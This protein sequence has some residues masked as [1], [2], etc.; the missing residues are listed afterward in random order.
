MNPL[1]KITLITPSFN[2]GLFIEKTIKSVLEQGYPDL[3]HI[4]IDGGSTDQTLDI[5]RAYGQQLT[6]LSEPDRGQTHAINKG[7]RLATGEV[8]GYVNSDDMLLPGSLLKV[9]HFFRDHPQASW[10]TGRCRMIDQN[11]EE[12]RKLITFYKNLWL[13]MR[14]SQMLAVMDYI[15]QPATFWRRQVI[16]DVGYFDERHNYAMDYDYWLRLGKQY[17]LWYLDEYLAC[18]RLHPA[19]KGGSS[20]EAQFE[21]DMQVAR[22]H[23]ESPTLLK[24]HEIHNALIVTVYK[25]LL[26]RA[27]RQSHSQEI[28]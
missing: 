14:R 18:F 17:K 19:S 9:G 16:E 3:E 1:P 25:L 21:D 5:L 20:F 15:S 10:L 13:Q 8:I 26:A 7:L 27:R 24:L 4:V 6:W 11:D 23:I 12:V 2:Q 22:S 28:S